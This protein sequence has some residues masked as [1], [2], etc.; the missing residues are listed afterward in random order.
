MS[1][2]RKEVKTDRFFL[3]DGPREIDFAEFSSCEF[4][5]FDGIKLIGL[6]RIGFNAELRGVAGNATLTC[7]KI[8]VKS[9]GTKR[10]P[11]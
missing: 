10:V 2:D 7:L 4:D 5:V 8:F 1:I 11:D 3:N 9:S 6:G